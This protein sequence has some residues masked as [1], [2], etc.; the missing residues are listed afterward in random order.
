MLAETFVRT[1]TKDRQRRRGR[2]T[3]EGCEIEA[4]RGGRRWTSRI[5]VHVVVTVVVVRQL[6]DTC[7]PCCNLAVVRFF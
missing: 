1:S 3:Q 6:L 5:Y 4:K 7:F 2:H